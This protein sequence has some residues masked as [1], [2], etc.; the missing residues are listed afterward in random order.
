MIHLKLPLT[1][2][3]LGPDVVF[4]PRLGIV[5]YAIGDGHASGTGMGWLLNIAR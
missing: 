2:G 3:V 5:D 4:T 1:G